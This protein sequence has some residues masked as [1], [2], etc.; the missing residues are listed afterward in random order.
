[1]VKVFLDID[2]GDAARHAEEVAA[3]QRAQAFLHECGSQYGLPSSVAD[4]DD[5][6]QQ[7][8]QESY[9]SD[10]NWSSKGGLASD[11]VKA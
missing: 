10:P 7:L 5:E 1:M 2:I 3:F 8:M 6:A 4:L 11:I 9:D